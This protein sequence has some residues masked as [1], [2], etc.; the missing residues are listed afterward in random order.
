LVPTG[1]ELAG[2]VMGDDGAIIVGD[3]SRVSVDDR[4]Y[5]RIAEK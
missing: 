3:Q 4:S 2:Y 5:I 1:D